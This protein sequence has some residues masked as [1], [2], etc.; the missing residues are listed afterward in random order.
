ML[1]RRASAS[2]MLGIGVW[3]RRVSV[4]FIC[5]RRPV[6]VMQALCLPFGKKVFSDY[7]FGA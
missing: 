4:S 6:E 1:G 2:K 5:G 7:R 3:C